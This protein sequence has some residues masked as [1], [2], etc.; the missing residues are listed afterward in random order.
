MSGDQSTR[1]HAAP[2][3][4]GRTFDADL[5]FLSRASGPLMLLA[6]AMLAYIFVLAGIA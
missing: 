5:N 2:A 4:G 6:R 1:E 3:A